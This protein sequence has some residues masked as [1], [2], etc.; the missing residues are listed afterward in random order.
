MNNGDVNGD[1]SLTVEDAQIAFLFALNLIEPREEE[2]Y[3]ADCNGD[4]Y[5]TAGD[6]QQIFMAALGAG[7]CVDPLASISFCN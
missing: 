3:A 7:S 4:G 5:V 1:R 6:N 2:N